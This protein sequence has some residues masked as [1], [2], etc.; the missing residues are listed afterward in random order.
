MAVLSAE[1][2]KAEIEDLG[3][4]AAGD[5][6]IGGFQVAVNDALGVRRIERVGDRDV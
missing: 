1:L 3:L 2:R 6:Y 5:D 4:S